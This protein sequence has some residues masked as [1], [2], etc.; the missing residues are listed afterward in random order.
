MK[1]R[2]EF[3]LPEEAAEFRAAVDGAALSASV[4]RYYERLRSERKYGREPE[5]VK[6][7]LELAQKWLLEAIEEE[8]I[9]LW[10]ES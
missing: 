3:R 10:E 5:V 7:T 9:R 6:A 1:A 2:L 8:G 4:Q